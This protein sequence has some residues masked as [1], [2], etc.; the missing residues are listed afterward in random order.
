MTTR[1]AKKMRINA[2]MQG[3]FLRL[4]VDS[5]MT[6]K[7]IEEETGLKQNTI[8]AYIRALRAQKLIYLVDKLADGAGLNTIEVWRWGPDKPDKYAPMTGTEKQRRYRARKRANILHTTWN[9]GTEN[10]SIPQ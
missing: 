7:E 1:P 3:I 10:A 4:L 6:R 2:L 8:G 5:P 9:K